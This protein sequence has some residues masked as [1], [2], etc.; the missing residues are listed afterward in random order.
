MRFTRTFGLCSFLITA[1]A[2]L[3]SYA[4][5]DTTISNDFWCTWNYVNPT[6]ASE[7]SRVYSSDLD[8][9]SFFEVPS[10]MWGR[11]FSSRPVSGLVIVVK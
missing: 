5:L 11:R 4:G 1:V 2:S 10:P 6:P 9:F 8:C 3:S 7:A